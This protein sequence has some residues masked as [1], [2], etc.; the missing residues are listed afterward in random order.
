MWLGC[1]VEE[2]RSWF[3][4]WCWLVLTAFLVEAQ[5]MRILVGLKCLAIFLG[6]KVSGGLL[7]GLPVVPAPLKVIRKQQKTI[8]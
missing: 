1:G 3:W 2:S 5:G 4:F 6:T 7:Y 8:K